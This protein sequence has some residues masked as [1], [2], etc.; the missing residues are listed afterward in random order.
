ME[1]QCKVWLKKDGKVVFGLGRAQLLEAVE[2]TGSLAAAAR[3]LGM[4]YRAAWGRLKASEERLGMKLLERAPHGRRP[5]RPTPAAKVLTRRFNELMAR[6]KQ[7]GQWAM[8]R[9][10]EEL[11][12][13][14]GGE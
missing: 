14:D 12:A 11:A 6:L 13:S 10:E 4:S 5:M 7:E 2:R 3:E 9:L 1:F 8:Q